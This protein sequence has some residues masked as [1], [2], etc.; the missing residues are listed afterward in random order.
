MQCKHS[1]DE[2]LKMQ[3]L[4]LVRLSCRLPLYH[5]MMA[6]GRQ[7]LLSQCT[8][9]RRSATSGV[10]GFKMLIV[11]G[12]TVL[13]NEWKRMV[14]WKINFPS[15]KGPRSM[16]LTSIT[17]NQGTKNDDKWFAVDVRSSSGRTKKHWQL[18]NEL[19]V[20]IQHEAAF[21]WLD[22]MRIGCLTREYGIQIGA[23]H[24]R[25]HQSIFRQIACRLFHLIVN[26]QPIH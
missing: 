3:Q 16:L 22:E 15:K 11:K 2:S 13:R 9:Y 17:A 20:K 5:V 14:N 19:T 10:V 18:K 7:P 26:N 1:K 21:A 12:F 24:G 4:T 25:P 23:L 8:S 6:L